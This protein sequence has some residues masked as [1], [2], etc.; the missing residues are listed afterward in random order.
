V[1]LQKKVPNV[2]L[3]IAG[4][5]R[6]PEEFSGGAGVQNLG[7]LDKSNP[8]HLRTLLNAYRE[9][10]VLALP[11]RHDP[12]PTVVREAMFFGLPCVA[13]DIFAM[14][15][16]IVDGETGYLIPPE[17]PE[18]L[19][20]RLELLLIDSEQR[21]RLGDAALERANSMF[22]W[23]RAGKKMHEILQQASSNSQSR[24]N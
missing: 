10:D 5:E 3:V 12:F 13:S 8:S 6:T 24:P 4:N 14:S 11:S 17:N 18:A 22:T 2:R 21:L 1:S 15:E 20:R 19:T 7:L 16:M 9:A 23:D